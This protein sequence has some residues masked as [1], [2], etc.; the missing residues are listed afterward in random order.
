MTVDNEEPIEKEE[1]TDF[2]PF[3]KY[4]ESKKGHEIAS[5]ILLIFEDV[6]KATL[7]NS[8]QHAKFEKWVQLGTILAV[9]GATSILTYFERFD[10]SVGILFGT[11]VGCLFG[12]R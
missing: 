10:A 6:K 2:S 1:E 5:R 3:L 9:V 11:L 8:T 7:E 12:K 4:L